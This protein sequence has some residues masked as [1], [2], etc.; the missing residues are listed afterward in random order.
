[1]LQTRCPPRER[2]CH[3]LLGT[4]PPSRDI[5]FVAGRPQARELRVHPLT[6]DR[7]RENPRRLRHYPPGST[8]TRPRRTGPATAGAVASRRPAHAKTRL[9]R[10]TAALMRHHRR[11][12]AHRRTAVGCAPT[13]AGIEIERA[14]IPMYSKKPHEHHEEYVRPGPFGVVA[15]ETEPWLGAEHHTDRAMTRTPRPRMSET[16]KAS[17]RK[18]VTKSRAM[19]TGVCSSTLPN[20]S[21]ASR[22]LRGYTLGA[23]GSEP[24]AGRRSA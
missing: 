7:R 3:D 14:T 17:S 22:S 2:Y 5:G 9:P 13:E 20:A 10:N 1:M 8:P 18:K 12:R 11:R 4:Y 16:A 15:V 19:N 21:A 24:S 6:Y 23:Q